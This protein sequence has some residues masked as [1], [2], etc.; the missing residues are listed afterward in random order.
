MALRSFWKEPPKILDKKAA[1]RD[2]ASTM[3]AVYKLVDERDG[4]RC[5]CCG[6]KDQ[7]EHNHLIPRSLKKKQQHTTQNVHLAC[8]TCHRLITSHWIWVEAT[9]AT[10]GCD[11]PLRFE[12]TAGIAAV[13]FAHRAIPA[14]VKIVELRR[15]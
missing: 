6:T 14:Q 8:R 1:K 11:A 10:K 12:M 13:V 7:V 9:D 4:R 15:D 3:R 2:D 5:R